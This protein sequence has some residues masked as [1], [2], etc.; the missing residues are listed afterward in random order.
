LFG[1]PP[2][3]IPRPCAHTLVCTRATKTT[4]HNLS[5]PRVARLARRST[6]R[7]STFLWRKD[8]S[9]RA[10]S[11][12][13]ASSLCSGASC[14]GRLRPNQPRFARASDP[15]P[16]SCACPR[17]ATPVIQLSALQQNTAHRAQHR[18]SGWLMVMR[19]GASFALAL[20]VLVAGAPFCRLHSSPSTPSRRADHSAASSVPNVR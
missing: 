9:C 13:I 3:K 18:R 15:C 12:R 11:V 17:H 8:P 7:P 19:L 5:L 14:D 2:S 4:Q 1:T 10:A 20:I 16:A 6:G